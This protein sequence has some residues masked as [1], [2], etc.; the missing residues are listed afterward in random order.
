MHEFNDLKR[1]LNLA[2]NLAKNQALDISRLK[3]KGTHDGFQEYQ[4]QSVL[5]ECYNLKGM[6]ERTKIVPF[7]PQ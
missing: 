1:R 3:V 6:C 4:I 2:T 7:P 5:E